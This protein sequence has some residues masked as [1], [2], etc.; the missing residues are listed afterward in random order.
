MP[1][2]NDDMD[3]LDEKLPAIMKRNEIVDLL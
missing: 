3:P 1:V 2:P